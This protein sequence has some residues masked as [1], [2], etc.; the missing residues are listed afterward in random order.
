M[1]MHRP[2]PPATRCRL[3]ERA[4]GKGQPMSIQK[5]CNWFT[6]VIVLGLIT[7]DSSTAAE[8]PQKVAAQTDRLLREEL[9]F[10]TATKKAPPRI[11]DERFLRRVSLDIIGRL[12]TPEEVTAFA[13]D[14]SPDKR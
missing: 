7:T 1:H 3:D 2:T 14:P 10:A 4:Q 5:L 13:L 6:W 9:P 11:D 12:P 8:D